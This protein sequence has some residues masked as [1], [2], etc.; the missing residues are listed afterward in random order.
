M[1]S[2]FKKN[3]IQDCQIIIL[4][5]E[6]WEIKGVLEIKDIEIHHFI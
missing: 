6:I 5:E 2:N 3:E 1:H 4:L